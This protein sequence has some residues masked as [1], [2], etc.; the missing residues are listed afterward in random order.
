MIWRLRRLW[1]AGW[2]LRGAL[3]LLVFTVFFHRSSLL[4]SRNVVLYLKLEQMIGVIARGECCCENAIYRRGGTLPTY[5]DVSA[6]HAALDEKRRS[7]GYSWRKIALEA[8]ISP[9]TLTRMAQGRRPD[10]DSFGALIS[11]LGLPAE[12][13]IRSDGAEAEPSTEPDALAVIST[14]L[15]ARRELSAESAEALQDI[16]RA[17]YN[18]LKDT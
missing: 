14:F 7:R 1:G 2:W 15:R 6:L 10:V 13:F 3:A 5:V 12:R 8:G 4:R 17:A 16:V 18:R 11:W 9:S